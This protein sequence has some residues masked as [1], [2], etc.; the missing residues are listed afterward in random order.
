MQYNNRDYRV[1][2]SFSISIGEVELRTA[3]RNAGFEDPCG[4]DISALRA[5]IIEAKKE[6][7]K[8]MYKMAMEKLVET[9]KKLKDG[10]I[11][12]FHFFSKIVDDGIINESVANTFL[13]NIRKKPIKRYLI[14]EERENTYR[15]GQSQRL[16]MLD[17]EDEVRDYLHK[18]FN[19]PKRRKKDH[20][21]EEDEIGFLPSKAWD[22]Q[23]RKSIT[24]ELNVKF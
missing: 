8:V 3:L 10:G 21:N 6:V 19:G 14:L 2:E 17:T 13:D 18:S 15:V 23:E 12:P 4:I 1:Q 24:F 9:A 16:T 7:K 11:E 5:S 22:L 20:H